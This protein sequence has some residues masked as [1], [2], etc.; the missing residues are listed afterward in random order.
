M[1]QGIEPVALPHPFLHTETN[2]VDAFKCVSIKGTWIHE[3]L[4]KRSSDQGHL[5]LFWPTPKID[6]YPNHWWHIS[7]FQSS[8]PWLSIDRLT[9]QLPYWL[10]E[11]LL[12]CWFTDCTWPFVCYFVPPLE[13][14]LIAW[15]LKQ[16]RHF[17]HVNASQ[18]FPL[19]PVV[20]LPRCCSFHNLSSPKKFLN[21]CSYRK[22]KESLTILTLQLVQGGTMIYQIPY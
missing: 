18:G 20:A 4:S 6:V 16:Y 21:L 17:G 11:N 2:A 12:V 5:F 7:P 9:V 19:Y 1:S 8:S 10:R 13:L 22:R 14:L 15:G 3:W